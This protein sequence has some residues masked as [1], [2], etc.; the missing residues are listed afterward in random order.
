M[1]I[2]AHITGVTNVEREQIIMY[3][4]KKFTFVNLDDFTDLIM[5]DG[6]M[7]QLLSEYEYHVNKSKDP[8]KSKNESRQSMLKSKEIEKKINTMWKVKMEFYIGS[9]NKDKKVILF[10]YCNFYRNVRIFVQIKTNYKIFINTDSR[11]Y[12]SNIIRHN[13]THFSEEICNG[14]F[15]MEHLNFDFL[16][17]KRELT[18]EVYLKNGYNLES[19][20]RIYRTVRVCD[21]SVSVPQVLFYG[22]KK[23]YGR[24]IPCTKSD[25][26]TCYT[27]FW[28]AV[29]DGIKSPNLQAKIGSD[30]SKGTITE[31]VE[32]G[33]ND[34]NTNTVVYSIITNESFIPVISD[35]YI[36]SFETSSSVQITEKT[37]VSNALITLRKMKIKIKQFR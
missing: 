32:N 21:V 28:M 27:E 6:T 4:A 36:Y 14:T 35:K 9:I 23:D 26:L 8:N 31:L 13:I 7:Q 34:L 15:S 1:P 25:K 19:M 10:G 24:S 16:L 5:E 22:S 11:K 2:L 17:K 29:I 18:M 37:Y 30:P 20:E 12:I 3:F 33:A